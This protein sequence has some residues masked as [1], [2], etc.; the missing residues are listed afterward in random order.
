[1]KIAL[2]LAV[3]C[4]A[5]VGSPF[6]GAGSTGTS[7]ACAA[8]GCCVMPRHRLPVQGGQQTHGVEV[9]RTRTTREC[10]HGGHEVE[11]QSGV[12]ARRSGRDGAGKA[13]E[14]RHPQS[15]VV[16]ILLAPAP[17]DQ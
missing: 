8:E 7:G 15:T 13:D 9:R 14:K 16:V 3:L 6:L 10:E 2:S 1:M 17:L 4:A 5:L 12:I 11:R